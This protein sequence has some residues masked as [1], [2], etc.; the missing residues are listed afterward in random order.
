MI[1][2]ILFSAYIIM[3]K[4]VVD[5]QNKYMPV[6][7]TYFDLFAYVFMVLSMIIAVAVSWSHNKNEPFAA[8]LAYAFFAGYFGFWYLLYYVIVY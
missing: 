8:K 3:I 1:I 7:D 2:I 4:V 6:C 5:K